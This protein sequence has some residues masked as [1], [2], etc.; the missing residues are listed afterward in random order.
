APINTPGW[1]SQPSISADGRTLYFVSTRAGGLGGYDIWKSDLISDGTWSVPVNLGHDINTPYD[2]Q[3][4]FIH[5]DNETLY[6]SSNGWPGL[7]NKDL[8]M[9]RLKLDESAEP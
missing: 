1:E 7:G 3:S 5:P 2:E 6:F 8:F 4:P 9:S